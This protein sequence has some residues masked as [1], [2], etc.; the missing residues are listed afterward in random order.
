MSNG[1]E[2][3]KATPERGQSTAVVSVFVKKSHALDSV[4]R[5]RRLGF[6][7]DHR[8]IF[9][10]QAIEL[11]GASTALIAKLGSAAADVRLGARFPELAAFSR[12]ARK[13][14]DRPRRRG[15]YL[16]VSQ[17]TVPLDLVSYGNEAW[18]ARGIYSHLCS[19]VP[20][21][22]NRLRRALTPA[23]FPLQSYLLVCPMAMDRAV[24]RHHQDIVTVALSLESQ[25]PVE[26]WLQPSYE[27]ALDAFSR[28]DLSWLHVDTHGQ[29]SSMMLGPSRSH[30]RFAGSADLP[31]KIDIP[32]TIVV[33]C[34]L[35]S[36]P[37]SIGTMLFARGARAVLGPCA[38]FQSL[39]VANSEDGEAGW[40]RVLFESMIAGRDLGTSLQ[41]ARRSVPGPGILKYAYLIAGSSQVRFER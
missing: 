13:C 27:R 32:I 36:G 2:A 38:I 6:D 24:P 5:A 25:L 30:G 35:T 41:L 14:V 22:H 39:G 19:S 40:Y 21:T 26:L 28:K 12:V 17:H 33:G 11:L 9:G 15:R 37:D 31:S 18:G 16:L 1:V 7:G 29:G 4:R 23:V 3:G 34:S 8:A 10:R 20:P